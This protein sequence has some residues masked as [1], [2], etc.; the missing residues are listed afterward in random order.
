MGEQLPG[1]REGSA[2]SADENSSIHLLKTSYVPTHNPS[3]SKN[4]PAVSLSYSGAGDAGEIISLPTWSWQAW[5]VSLWRRLTSDPAVAYAL[6]IFMT[7][8]LLLFALGACLAPLAPVDPPLGSGLLRDVDPHQW[9]PGFLLL[10][11]WQRWDTNWYLHIAIFGYS[12][13]DGS[14]NFP[15][16][17]PALVG[18]LGRVLLDQYMLAAMLISNFAYVVALIYFYRLSQRL[19]SE[20]V[21]RRGILFVATFPTA[22]FL[23]S[24]Y[25]ESIYLALVLMAFYYAEEKRWLW[26]AVLAALASITRLQGAILVLPLGYMYMQQAGW[27]W[28][29]IG[30][31]GLLLAIA[32]LS[33]GIYLVYVYGI[34]QDYNFNDHLQEIWGIKFVMPWTSF[35]SGM[36]GFFD[37][38]RVQNLPYNALDFILLVI[39]IAMTVIWYK[40]K[41]P[42]AYLLYSVLSM[43]VFLTRE[44]SSDFFW[45]SMNRYL[46]SVFPVFMLA[47]QIGPRF[48][49]RLGGVFQAV[50]AAL[51]IFWMWAG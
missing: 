7:H 14:T 33:L 3:L 16:L 19:F 9:G 6:G 34:L 2:S 15:P 35:F 18:V 45:M 8:R 31:D 12:P 50:W 1:S 21:A 11:P 43:V 39:F 26:V 5:L 22:F 36:F 40:K 30:R 29:K 25:T 47:G 32:P 42:M 46:L 44:G 20:E 24:G 13:G 51:F 23:A 17:Y 37:P 10:G 41:L 4:L 38:N 48:M 28:R 27:N 49:I